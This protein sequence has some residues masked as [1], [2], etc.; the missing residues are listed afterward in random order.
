MIIYAVRF[1]VEFGAFLR[2]FEFELVD[3][4]LF[5]TMVFQF[6]LPFETFMHKKFEKFLEDYMFW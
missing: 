6:S 2:D 3:L 1:A 4:S 5:G